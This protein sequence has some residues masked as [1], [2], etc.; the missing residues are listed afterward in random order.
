MSGYPNTHAQFPASPLFLLMALLALRLRSQTQLSWFLPCP[1]PISVPGPPVPAHSSRGR[2]QFPTVTAHPQVSLRISSADPS[3]TLPTHFPPTLVTYTSGSEEE[4]FRHARKQSLG[5]ILVLTLSE[6]RVGWAAIPGQQ[7]AGGMASRHQ[8]EGERRFRKLC[9][10]ANHSLRKQN[11]FL[12]VHGLFPEK[13]SGMSSLQ[14]V[15]S[16]AH[17]TQET[18]YL[19]LLIYYKGY[20]EG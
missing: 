12:Q 10:S 16:A 19:L 20:I 7:E 18:V 9:Y 15:I 5:Q 17:R 13:S 6:G 4:D 14:T 3:S 2:H 8:Q 11:P 1:H